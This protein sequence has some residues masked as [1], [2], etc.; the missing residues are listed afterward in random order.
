MH[1]VIEKL[2]R[3]LRSL[4]FLGIEKYNQVSDYFKTHPKQRKLTIIGSVV[5]GPPLLFLLVVWIETP[6]G[7]ALRNIQNQVA[8]EVYSADS[9]LLGRYYLQ[10]RTEVAYEEISPTVYNALIATED[11]RFYEHRGIDFRSLGRVLV[12]SIFL[13]DES[14]GGGSTITQQLSKNLYPR[15]K[16][17]ILSMPINKMREIITAARLEGMYTKE[18]LLVMYL[19]T[20]PFADLTFGI[21]SAAK[22][23][24]STTAK[25]LTTNQAALLIGML[26]ATHTYNPR[27]FPERAF[28]RRNVVLYQ[29]MKNK[30]LEQPAYDSLK[31]LPLRLKYYKGSSTD[32]LAPYFKEYLKTELQ[33]WIANNKKPDG[34]DYNIFTDGLKIYTTLDSRLQAYAEKAMIQ[35]MTEIQNIFFNHWGR[36]KPWKDNE[37]VVLEAVRRSLRYKKLKESG[38]DEE[39]I[40]KNFQTPIATRIFTWQ[41]DRD[42]M[43]KPIDS[44]KHHLQ[45]L[46]AGFLAMDPKSGEVKAWVGGIDY[47]FF[48]YDHVRTSTKRQV[49]SIFKPIVYTT[50]LEAGIPPCDLISASRP[51]YIDDEG[52]SWTPRNTQMD[53]EVNYSMRG[54]LAYSVNTVAVKLIQQAGVDKT[55]KMAQKMGITSE[56]PD[57]PSI[58]LGAASIS[59]MEMTTAFSTFAN[60][61][62]ASPAYCIASI[63]DLNGNKWSDFKPKKSVEPVASK[64]TIT[65][66]LRMLQSVVHEGTASRLRGRYAVY[67]DVAGKTGTTQ[68]NADGWFMAI[69]PK[70]VVGT[71]VGADDPRIRFRSTE[72]GQGSSTALPMFAYF[73]REVNADPAFKDI[74]DAK[75]P[76]IS[77]EWYE[78]LDCDLYQLD[79]ALIVRI[80]KEMALKDSIESTN[81]DTLATP[82]KESFLEFLYRRKLKIQLRNALQDSI[83]KA[84]EAEN[85]IEEN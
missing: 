61:G 69:T 36:E 33:N 35:Q 82:R 21:Q 71:W 31:V 78:K 45:F 81:Q 62:I 65:L 47:S 60:E 27:L 22:R 1:P 23:F 63:E 24:F 72:L 43:M 44:V 26:K 85:I 41:G 19:N 25:D 16:Y 66:M 70:L 10:D 8:S 42:V 75:F 52:V 14:S 3:Y 48:Q 49:G 20:I 37:N 32:D 83:Q 54:A 46:N 56:L 74:A 28:A 12:K 5:F 68:A 77:S 59:L 2:S 73:M 53:Y 55:I 30:F 76:T 13:Q 80:Q 67:N 6:S 50:A 15:K 4:I 39:E 7:R 64:E 57:V 40:I 29:M 38:M 9:V 51:T 17:W 11:I 18:E 84:K 34:S 79:S 58:A